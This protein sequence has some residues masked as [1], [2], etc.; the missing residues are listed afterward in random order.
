ML[1]PQ[2]FRMQGGK[3][4]RDS[5]LTE[6]QSRFKIRDMDEVGYITHPEMGRQ[7]DTARNGEPM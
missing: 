5:E 6:S 1:D 2:I 7:W 4:N 3:T